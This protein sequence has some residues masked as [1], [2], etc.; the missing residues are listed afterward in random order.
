VR[1]FVV[2]NGPPGSGKSTIAQPLADALGLPLF[3]KDAIKETLADALEV[4]DAAT[5]RVLGR[6]AI[7]LLYTLARASQGA[8]LEG[9]FLRTFAVDELRAL[10]G[11][12]VEVFCRCDR[13]ELERRYR[14]RTRHPCHFDDARTADELW[15]DDTLQPVGGGW[16]VLELDTSEPVDLDALVQAVGS[17]WR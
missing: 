2:L 11:D 10:D 16:P 6:T 14:A 17:S 5:S 1:R 13:A 15:N 8:V 7:Q 3:S 12:V 4:T 9:P